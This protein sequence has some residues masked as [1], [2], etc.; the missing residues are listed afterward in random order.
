MFSLILNLLQKFNY[1][2]SISDNKNVVLNFKKIYAVSYKCF[3]KFNVKN[4]QK[5]LKN[6]GAVDF[7]KTF[8]YICAQIA[9]IRA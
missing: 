5:F 9:Y 8:L 7:L 6:Y 2:S 3:Y 1:K 4:N